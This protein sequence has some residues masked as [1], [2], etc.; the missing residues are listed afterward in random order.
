[1][2]RPYI[3][4][5]QVD[6]PCVNTQQP[7]TPFVLPANRGKL[8]S[9]SPALMDVDTAQNSAILNNKNAFDSQ[10][11]TPPFLNIV[12]QINIVA[13]SNPSEKERKTLSSNSRHRKKS[14]TITRSATGEDEP[15]RKKVFI[16]LGGILRRDVVDPST[17]SSHRR[18]V[19]SLACNSSIK[20]L[21]VAEDTSS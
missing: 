2:I 14:S 1:M 17:N 12:C 19:T 11:Q 4:H 15:R 7:N 6:S 3:F 5:K 8:L 16:R 20:T 21:T 10:I 13:L 18:A 9:L